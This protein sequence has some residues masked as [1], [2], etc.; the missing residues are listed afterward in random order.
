MKSADIVRQ[1][2]RV[3]PRYTALFSDALSIESLTY[4][5]GLVTCVT[6]VPHDLSNGDVVYIT[7]AL[8]PVSITSLTRIGNIATAITASNHDFTDNYTE[9]VEI[10]GATP[11]AYNGTHKFI[12]QPNRRTFEFEIL[13]NPATPATGNIKVLCDFKYGYNGQHIVTVVD[14]TTFTYAISS[15]PESPA[16]GS[17]ALHKGFRI[18]NA[19]SL[20]RIEEAYTK[21]LPNKMW[22]F[23]VLDNV[24]ASRDRLA[25]TDSTTTANRGVDFRQTIVEPFTIYIAAPC[26]DEISGANVRDKMDEV[27]KA[28]CRAIVG[29]KTETIFYTDNTFLINFASHGLASYQYAYYIHAFRFENQAVIT[30]PDTV[31]ID[32]SVAFRDL[33]FDIHNTKDVVIQQNFVDLDDVPFI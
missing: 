8:T 11:T 4:S 10:L 33:N 26:S 32:E 25:L 14:E 2:Q 22:A 15:A 27:F 12:H 31:D 30:M 9:T 20:E 24:M 7:G 21:Q 3:L 1:L 6:D 28:L 13:G 18:S 17:I 23:V 19:V 29:F 5:G 16:V